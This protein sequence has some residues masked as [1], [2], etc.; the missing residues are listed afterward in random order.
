MTHILKTIKR[1]SAQKYKR[2]ILMM[3]LL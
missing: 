1:V 2:R 3:E